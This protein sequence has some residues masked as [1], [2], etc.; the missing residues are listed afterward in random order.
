MA[1]GDL[2]QL[3]RE[4][5]LPASPEEAI[6]DKIPNPHDDVDYIVRF[7]CPEFTALCPITGQ[8][9]FAHLVIELPTR[10]IHPREQVAQ[11]VSGL[12]SQSR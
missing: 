6:L 1:N 5:A 3:G 10:R 8:P 4:S 9:D 2:S 11:T 12:V 7:T